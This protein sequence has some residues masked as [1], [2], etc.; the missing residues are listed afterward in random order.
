MKSHTVRIARLFH[1]TTQPCATTHEITSVRGLSRILPRGLGSGWGY[2]V[3]MHRPSL[4]A[5][6]GWETGGEQGCIPTPGG[7][8]MV[9]LIEA[10]G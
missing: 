6:G 8:V 5:L 4:L 3:R 9:D 1:G 2:S 7:Y 10:A